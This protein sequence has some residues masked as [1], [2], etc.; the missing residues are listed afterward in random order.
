MINWY[1]NDEYEGDNSRGDC[2]F[3]G[4]PGS[5]W[6]ELMDDYCCSDCWETQSSSF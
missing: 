3:C 1:E 5:P 6:N 4:K 2:E